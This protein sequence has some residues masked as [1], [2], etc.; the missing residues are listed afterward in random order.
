M[1]QPFQYTRM[2]SWLD[3][4]PDGPGAESIALEDLSRQGRPLTYTALSKRTGDI[5]RGLDRL[6]L[7]RGDRIAIW[8]ANSPDWM[9]IHFAAVLGPTFSTPGTLSTVSPINAR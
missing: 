8:L 5:A 3:A 6:G 9:A 2:A 4:L 1:N 7:R